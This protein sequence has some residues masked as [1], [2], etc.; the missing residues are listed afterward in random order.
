MKKITSFALPLAFLIS[1]GSIILFQ[2]CNKDTAAPLNILELDPAAAA[3]MAKETLEKVD[4]QIAD[5][6]QI[7]LW[8]TDSLLADPIALEVDRQGRVYI[9]RTNRQKNSE[10]D[11]R[12]HMDWTTESIGLETVEDRRA[13]LRKIFAPENSEKN[14]WLPDLNGDSIHD[15]KDLAVEMDQVYRL[16]DRSG[17]GVADYSQVVLEDFHE[18]VTDVAGGVLIHDGEMFLAQGP[19]VWRLK[20]TNGDGQMDKKTSISHGYAI[21]IGFSGHG[22]SGIT[23]GP[24]GKIY[25]GIGDIGSNVTDQT[26]KQWKNPNQGAIFRANPDGS[27]FEVFARGLRNTHEFVFDQYGNLFSED[28]DG[29][30]PGER[31]RLVYIVNGSDTGWRTNWQFGKYTD[32]DNNDY[33]VWMDE[34]LHIPHFEGQAAYIT[35]PLMN[36]L[37]GP[38]G[39]LYNPG[40]ALSEAY[41]NH[42]FLVSFTGTPARSPIHAFQMKP[43][44]ASFEFAGD[45]EILKGILPTG[46]DFGPDGALYVAD[47]L[48][49]WGTKNRGRVWKMDVKPEDAHPLR[50]ETQ[51]LLGSNFLKKSSEELTELLKHADMRVRLRAQWTLAKRPKDGEKAF[52][53]MMDQK[54]HQLGRIHGIWG[55]AQ[56]AR[57]EMPKAASLMPL[58][59]DEDSEIR[60]QAAKWIGDI[61]YAAAG[62]QL[63]PLLKDQSLRV[64]FFA[65]EAL[66]RIAH[67]AAVAPII[68]MLEENN[69]EDI[70]LRHAGACALARIGESTPLIALA[71][72]QNQALK[73]GAVVALRRMQD[74]GVAAFLNDS[75]ELVLAEAARAINDDYSIP[76]ALPDLAQSLANTSS[77]NEAYIRRAINA[78]LRVGKKE[79]AQ[80]LADYA[81]K[82]NAPEE[83]RAEAIATLGSWNKPSVLDRV[84]GRYR[85][86]IKTEQGAVKGIFENIYAKGLTDRSNSIKQMTADAIARLDIKSAANALKKMVATDRNSDNKIAALN[87][88]GKMKDAEL[89]TYVNLALNDRSSEVRQNAIGLLANSDMDEATQAKFLADILKKPSLEEQQQAFRQLGKLAHPE[90]TAILEAQFASLKSGNFNPSLELELIEA[91]EAQGNESLVN[92]YEQ[93]VKERGDNL[94]EKYSFALE[95]GDARNGGRI[96]YRNQAAQCI[97]CHIARGYG[98]EV[99]PA[100]D[101]IGNILTKEQILESLINPSA[102]IA[103]GYGTVV[104]TMEGG[105][106]ITGTLKEENN[107]MLII[108]TSDAEPIK[109]PRAKIQNRQDVPSSMPPMGEVLNKRELRD[110]V[111]LLMSLKQDS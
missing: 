62:D 25:W 7:S 100:L 2:S 58:L 11:I 95:G 77:S 50:A 103:P 10:F 46:I 14:S 105:E 104:L 70:L 21:H 17:D 26:G 61:R 57:K 44:G 35:P 12:G 53:Q 99:G 108:Q 43:S 72:H 71:G 55:M 96:F 6:F 40:T 78:N 87:A 52:Q 3:Q 36:Y 20:D 74:P 111:A 85:G 39:M 54:E 60:A 33:K 42:F 64:R 73:L 13:F 51:E 63:I 109:V 9:T 15:W 28:N 66:G 32:P 56:L 59:K 37:N 16:E 106:N 4:P 27:D 31:E 1:I 107:D 102:R 79:N 97:R 86:E 69:G 23:M 38:T 75:D 90:A 34:K 84:D 67:K 29:D 94:M 98:G 80:I 22:M 91:I 47:W 49:G 8:A 18:E 68:N 92:A 76:Q 88:L 110:V 65:A 24:D 93:F 30:H 19:D 41:Q 5:D 89:P 45:K 83:L 48:E 101:N 82:P 81:V